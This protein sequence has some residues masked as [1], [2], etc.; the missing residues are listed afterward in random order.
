MTDWICES[1][2]ARRR[3][4]RSKAKPYIPA[5]PGF[6]K[7][8]TRKLIIRYFG[9]RILMG[10]IKLHREEDY[11]G[12]CISGSHKVVAIINAIMSA[13]S[14]SKFKYV[15]E[16]I[17]CSD[18]W[19]DRQRGES[20]K[21]VDWLPSSVFQSLLELYKC[22]GELTFDDQSC[23]YYGRFSHKLGARSGREGKADPEAIPFDSLN[24]CDGFTMGLRMKLRS[25][26]EHPTPPL[27]TVSKQAHTKPSTRNLTHTQRR[28]LDM[29]VERFPDP[30]GLHVTTDSEYT[31]FILYD[32]LLG[33][34]VKAT[35]TM[36]RNWIGT[37]SHHDVIKP[38]EP[39]EQGRHP[40]F[41]I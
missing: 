20:Y 13:M 26:D 21:K 33:I 5:K 37:H 10:Q 29:I 3:A 18:L 17:C 4:S 40:L 16:N 8:L 28:L 9:V 24:A 15:R 31:S 41:A 39:L 35:G 11:W 27:T 2:E 23:R 25:S 6:A 12:G 22:D 14:Y 34:G 19:Y 38:Q 32:A 30:R 1:S 7:K 36:K